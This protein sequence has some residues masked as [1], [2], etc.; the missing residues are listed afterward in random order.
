MGLQGQWNRTPNQSCGESS[1][2][3]AFVAT[4]NPMHLEKCQ[5]HC[6]FRQSGLSF[7]AGSGHVKFN[8]PGFSLNCCGFSAKSPQGAAWKTIWKT[9]FCTMGFYGFLMGFYG[10]F[11]GCLRV[12]PKPGYHNLWVFF[13]GKLWVFMGWLWVFMGKL[14]VLAPKPSFLNPIREKKHISDRKP[15]SRANLG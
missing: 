10:F 6:L 1:G 2:F 15:I 14:W 13:M 9:H 11:M 3:Q 4:A 7:H 5:N 12:A 8:I